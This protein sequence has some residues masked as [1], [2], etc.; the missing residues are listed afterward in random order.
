M[1]S[2]NNSKISLNSLTDYHFKFVVLSNFLLFIFYT[3]FRIFMALKLMVVEQMNFFTGAFVYQEKGYPPYTLFRVFIPV[4]L[5]VGFFFLYRW[6]F[7]KKGQGEIVQF[8]RN[9]LKFTKKDFLRYTLFLFIFFVS[10][11]FIPSFL[12][13]LKN[14]NTVYS[15]I[16]FD[17]YTSIVAIMYRGNYN[18]SVVP[19]PGLQFGKYYSI[20][21]PTLFLSW[22]MGIG[23]IPAA[24][25]IVITSL[26]FLMII[27]ILFTFR[28]LVFIKEESSLEEIGA[29][30]FIGALVILALQL[31]VFQ[32]YFNYHAFLQVYTYG[33]LGATGG[34]YLFSCLVFI[35]SHLLRK[36]ELNFERI[37]LI[38][39]L[40][41]I[42]SSML[43]QSYFNLSLFFIPTSGVILAILL[44][45][46]TSGF[47]INKSV[48]LFLAYFI[49]NYGSFLALDI[50][51]QYKMKPVEK[52]NTMLL[53]LTFCFFVFHLLNRNWDNIILKIFEKFRSWF[54][55]TFFFLPFLWFFYHSGDISSIKLLGLPIKLGGPR[56]YFFSLLLYS[57]VAG[58]IIFKFLRLTILRKH[59]FLYILT[60]L[61]FLS[62][63]FIGRRC[64]INQS[65]LFQYP[66]FYSEDMRIS[67]RQNLY[68][69][70]ESGT[71]VVYNK[72]LVDVVQYFAR[73]NIND[74]YYWLFSKTPSLGVYE[75]GL[76]QRILISQGH[77]LEGITVKHFDEDKRAFIP[78]WAKLQVGEIIIEDYNDFSEHI[79]D[80][81]KATEW[82]EILHKRRFV[83]IDNNFPEAQLELL[84][85]S[86]LFHKLYE[87]KLYKVYKMGRRDFFFEIPLRINYE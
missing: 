21:I 13:L 73:N 35:I 9:L 51:P 46:K 7:G 22:L 11:S 61:I 10:L 36:E 48:V 56:I 53:G 71:R 40:M 27:N 20:T 84:N 6:L 41:A 52:L 14:L 18:S 78:N 70:D 2:K 38:G 60:P 26:V 43:V 81:A 15:F 25:N 66:D 45:K 32:D 74:M 65:L 72:Y 29:L 69:F 85:K 4:F 24:Y 23:N 80:I 62:S 67:N 39:F 3:L 37:K 54:L 8:F 30:L 49:L 42:S 63:L 28:S 57:L 17:S 86:P 33:F 31:V 19:D 64:E 68:A 47:E 34:T 44:S 5:L 79:I 59:S 82:R 50:F 83:I 16:D 12:L 75:H 58:F 1:N 76:L 87:N 77:K 55:L